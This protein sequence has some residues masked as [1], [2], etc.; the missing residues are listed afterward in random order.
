MLDEPQLVRNEHKVDGRQDV[1]RRRGAR[2]PEI[3]GLGSHERSPGG[4]AFSAFH[5][6]ALGRRTPRVTLADVVRRR[7]RP[8]PVAL[9]AL[10][11]ARVAAAREVRPCGFA[12][13]R[14][15]LWRQR[16]RSAP[17]P[18]ACG[19]PRATFRNTSAVRQWRAAVAVGAGPTNRASVAGDACSP[20]VAGWRRASHG[21]SP[22]VSD[23][24]RLA[25]EPRRPSAGTALRLDRRR[26]PP[27]SYR[28]SALP[29]PGEGEAGSTARSWPDADALRR[30]P[31]LA[32]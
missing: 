6:D 1:L 18:P 7:A 27:S 32:R 5:D 30:G 28:I 16:L 26:G 17:I 21:V 15:D 4:A 25:A 31:V 13:A 10:R 11:V 12:A 3:Q 29:R 24:L 2:F 9:V 22:A 14:I 8:R 23:A 19:S 20:R